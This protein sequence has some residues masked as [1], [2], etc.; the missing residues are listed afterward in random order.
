MMYFV[1]VV[2]IGTVLAVT[3][4][5]T[6]RWS[7]VLPLLLVVVGFATGD[8]PWVT[9]GQFPWLDLDTPI[10]TVYRVLALQLGGLTP[11][12]VLLIALALVG[13]V[14]FVVAARSLRP[15]ALTI[16]VLSFLAIAMVASTAARD[17]NST[18]STCWPDDVAGTFD[19]IDQT[20]GQDACHSVPFPI[21]ATGR[22][23]RLD[24]RIQSRS[25]ASCVPRSRLVRL[26][27]SLVSEVRARVRPEDR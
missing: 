19:W 27:G 3:D 24:L 5:R 20:V 16:A 11:V 21:R 13:T 22:Q 17:R 23:P 8:I 4:S 15:R 26:H 7:L 2:L 14:L 9:W 25:S 10:S 1:P 6:P 12:R 18:R